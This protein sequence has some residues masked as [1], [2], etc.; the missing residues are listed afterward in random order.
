MSQSTPLPSNLAGESSQARH[1]VTSLLTQTND[2][3]APF[4]QRVALATV[5]FPHGAQKLLGW[6]GGFG[7]KGTMN[8]FTGTMGIPTVLAFGVVA[9]EFFAPIL[10][11]L[12]LGTRL[13]SLS[14][15]VVMTTALFM[16]HLQNGFF[17]NWFGLQK[18]EG[19][20][21]DLLLLGLAVSLV[22]SGAG[23]LSLDR[24]F[25]RSRVQ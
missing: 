25:T 23:R 1:A 17:M 19:F 4:I 20:E 15:G 24:H 13:A 7:F 11:I 8:F 12:G 14:I 16:V 21:F 10:L 5:M 18:G 6:F 9:V 22:I 2:S 3:L